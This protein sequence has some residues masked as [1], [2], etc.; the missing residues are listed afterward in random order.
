MRR[1]PISE[2][3]RP[4]HKMLSIQFLKYISRNQMSPHNVAFL[5]TCG[6]NSVHPLIGLQKRSNQ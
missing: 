3:L 5:V 2:A 4:H 1:S 6:Q